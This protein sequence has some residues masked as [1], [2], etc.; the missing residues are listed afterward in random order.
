MC[1]FRMTFH[2]FKP[3]LY[4]L[5]IKHFRAGRNLDCT[6][7]A[8]TWGLSFS[9][10]IR[11]TAPVS[12]LLQLVRIRVRIDPPHPLICRNLEATEWGGPSDETGKTEAPCHSRCG[13]IKISPRSKAL[14]AEHR[15]KFC[16]PSPAMVTS[17]YK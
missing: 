12:R 10:L 11:R 17:T 8:V 5:W 1:I 16:S 7:H 6:T 15:P 14:S 13:T 3:N 9:S 4:S 2:Y